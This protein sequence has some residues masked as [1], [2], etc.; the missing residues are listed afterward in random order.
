MSAYIERVLDEEEASEEER[1]A[2]SLVT[3]ALREL[4]LRVRDSPWFAAWLLLFVAGAL[5]FF[6]DLESRAPAAA[7][8]PPLLLAA[9][10][11]GAPCPPS[12]PREVAHCVVEGANNKA[13]FSRS[14]DLFVDSVESDDPLCAPTV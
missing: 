4:V 12:L 5:G 13:R 9:S 14:L 7:N 2:Q 6:A 3:R 1:A 10:V 8:A 11:L